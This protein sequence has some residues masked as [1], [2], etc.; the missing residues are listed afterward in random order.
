MNNYLLPTDEAFI[1][2]VARA[3]AR[4]RLQREALSALNQEVEISAENI[5]VL[6]KSFDHIFER[7]WSGNM[8]EDMSQKSGYRADALAAIGAIN[9]KLITSPQE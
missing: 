9:L 5:E 3:I 2:D 8:P 7:L 4:N 6:E 1:E